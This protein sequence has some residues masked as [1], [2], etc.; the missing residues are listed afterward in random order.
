MDAS[1]LLCR[2]MCRIACKI[3]LSLLMF[4]IISFYPI[5]FLM[6]KFKFQIHF[7]HLEPYKVNVC[8]WKNPLNDFRC[9]P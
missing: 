6:V 3:H 9:S 1:L 4:F 8:A 2:S 7:Y 5:S